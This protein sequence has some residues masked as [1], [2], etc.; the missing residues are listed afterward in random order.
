MK[1]GPWSRLRDNPER[2]SG[3][4]TWRKCRACCSSARTR[5]AVTIR[6]R[7]PRRG[8]VVDNTK[9]THVVNA[10]VK[11]LPRKRLTFLRDIWTFRGYFKY[12][13]WVVFNVSVNHVRV[14]LCARELVNTRAEGVVPQ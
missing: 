7:E 8:R 1:G 14:R 10:N 9:A 6:Q 11:R 3:V 4:S 5:E 13:P 2:E 12:V